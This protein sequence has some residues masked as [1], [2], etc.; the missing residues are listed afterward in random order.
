MSTGARILQRQLS[1]QSLD[2]TTTITRGGTPVSF[3]G[4]TT[5]R[6]DGGAIFVHGKYALTGS[7]PTSGVWMVSIPALAGYGAQFIGRLGYVNSAGS[8]GRSSN[9]YLS[10]GGDII[11]AFGDVS[12]PKFQFGTTSIVAT[13]TNGVTNV[14]TFPQDWGT[15]VTPLVWGQVVSASGSA[16]GTTVLCHTVSN[17]Q[18]SLRVAFTATVT[19]TVT[20]EW[21]AVSNTDQGLYTPAAGS[22]LSLHG[23]VN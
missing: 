12:I 6:S 9:A 17:T 5:L 3:T 4:G 7:I 2:P 21:F 18:F 11:D 23:M 22:I 10:N 14:V 19:I 20:A 8:V 1:A 15:G 16:I 13:A